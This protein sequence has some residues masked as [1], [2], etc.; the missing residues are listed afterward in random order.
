MPLTR[1]IQGGGGGRQSG[2]DG[3]LQRWSCCLCQL[4]ATP[5]ANPP[6]HSSGPGFGQ[7]ALPAKPYSQETRLPETFGAFLSALVWTVRHTFCP[8][9]TA[10]CSVGMRPAEGGCGCRPDG[11][12]PGITFGVLDSDR[13]AHPGGCG[14]RSSVSGF[15]VQS[16]SHVSAAPRFVEAGRPSESAGAGRGTRDCRPLVADTHATVV[17]CFGVESRRRPCSNG[18]VRGAWGLGLQARSAACAPS[19]PGHVVGAPPRRPWCTVRTPSGPGHVGQ[20]GEGDGDAVFASKCNNTTAPLARGL[21][22][23]CGPWQG[24]TRQRMLGTDGSCSLANGG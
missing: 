15:G 16:A 19:R 3:S 21:A 7:V 2:R 12:D 18:R 5:G 23:L 10:T 22:R 6:R 17:L 13:A 9:R 1:C 24:H 4:G 20:G 11:G 8:V 14:Y